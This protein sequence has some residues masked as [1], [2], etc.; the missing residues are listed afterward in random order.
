MRINLKNIF[1][2]NPYYN[3]RSLSYDWEFLMERYKSI[4]NKEMLVV[5]IG[6][7]N[8]HKT[9]DLSMYCKKL[10]GI[11]IDK[12]KIYPPQENIEIINADWQN[13]NSIFK[14]NSI[15]IIVSSHVIEHVPD[16]LKALNESYEILKPSGRLL[17]ITPNKNRFT[18]YIAQKFHLDKY[19]L[20]DEH[21][22]EYTEKGILALLSKSKFRNYTINSV[23][24]GLHSGKFMFYF[25]NPN[26]F[27]K[28]ANFFVVQL[29][30]IA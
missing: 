9:L 30:K 7:S 19:F 6:C 3:G 22:R 8:F 15:D 1:I 5:E 13:L 20:Y 17:F 16:D 14:P 27:R 4:V 25:K 21:E 23:A 26:Y 18:R 12:T 11:E 2:G 24:L 29:Q 28:L 10:I